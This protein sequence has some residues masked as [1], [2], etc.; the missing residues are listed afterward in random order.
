MLFWP[1]YH[2]VPL[3]RCT[4]VIS[5]PVAVP[6]FARI[7]LS[8]EQLQEKNYSPCYS[9]FLYMNAIQCRS[10]TYQAKLQSH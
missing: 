8:P 6:V 4:T 5:A 3:L 2:T 1:P 9:V 7:R 10:A